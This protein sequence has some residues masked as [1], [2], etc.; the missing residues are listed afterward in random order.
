MIDIARPR[1]I[2]GAQIAVVV[3]A[4]LC[5]I[6]TSAWAKRVQKKARLQESDGNSR[7]HE[8]PTPKHAGSTPELT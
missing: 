6:V 5:P 1:A 8:A 4:V 2:A 3:S 7:E